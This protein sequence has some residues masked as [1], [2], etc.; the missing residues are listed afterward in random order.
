M[1]IKLQIICRHRLHVCGKQVVTWFWD[2]KNAFNAVARTKIHQL[3]KD[4]P[5]KDHISDCGA[6]I[7]MSEGSVLLQPTD[8]VAQGSAAAADVFNVAMSNVVSPIVPLITSKN[9]QVFSPLTGKMHMLGFTSFVDHIAQTSEC[10]KA[11]Q[12]PV[13]LSRIDRLVSFGVESH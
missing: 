1:A 8:G 9:M 6:R 2:T 11:D 7:V 13:H 12:V 10:D 5:Y 3:I 4:K